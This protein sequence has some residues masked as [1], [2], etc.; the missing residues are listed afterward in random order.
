MSHQST[1]LISVVASI[2]DRCPQRAVFDH[3][4]D[5][6][7]V[8][9]FVVSYRLNFSLAL[10]LEYKLFAYFMNFFETTYVNEDYLRLSQQK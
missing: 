7:L 2:D 5:V 10:R 1:R 6:G 4:S 9:I 8:A 3:R